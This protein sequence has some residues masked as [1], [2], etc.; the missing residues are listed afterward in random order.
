MIS[1]PHPQCSRLE[2]LV[3]TLRNHGNTAET[4]KLD[5]LAQHNKWTSADQLWVEFKRQERGQLPEEVAA[6][7]Q[8]IPTVDGE[9]K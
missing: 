8:P 3:A 9:G 7:A 6:S 4:V 2:N 1:P 5:V